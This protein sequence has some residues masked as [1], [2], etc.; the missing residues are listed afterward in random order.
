MRHSI[1]LIMVFILSMFVCINI[2][3]TEKVTC[4]GDTTTKRMI[5]MD[6]IDYFLPLRDNNEKKYA[7]RKTRD[8]RQK[9]NLFFSSIDKIRNIYVVDTIHIND[10]Y[11]LKSKEKYYFL[12]LNK[13]FNRDT[14][15]YLDPLANKD[16]YLVDEGFDLL[17]PIISEVAYYYY[18]RQ[19]SSSMLYLNDLNLKKVKK[20]PFG[21]TLYKPAFSKEK[22]HIFAVVLIKGSMFNMCYYEGSDDFGTY[23]GGYTAPYNFIDNESYYILLVPIYEIA[24]NHWMNK[25]IE[26]Y[27]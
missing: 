5:N 7:N 16:C 15:N 1:A 4:G 3:A 21:Y 22:Y 24:Y 23:A 17:S 20:L 12:L 11:I 27:Q 14:F 9:K 19:I 26:Q 2:N 25:M 10:Y 18:G 13:T 8:N 6:K